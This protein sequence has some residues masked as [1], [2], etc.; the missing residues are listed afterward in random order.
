M[1]V[2]MEKPKFDQDQFITSTEVSRKFSIIRKQA[3]EKPLVVTDNGRFDTVILDYQLYE[4]MYSRLNE[5]EEQL[6]IQVLS[7]R[8]EELEINPEKGV[9]WR[10]VRRSSR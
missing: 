6:E 8:L 2:L 9:T 10:D 4:N 5:L 3:K 7:K 1:S